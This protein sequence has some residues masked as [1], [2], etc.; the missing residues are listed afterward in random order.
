M[1]ARA[2]ITGLT[3]GLCVGSLNTPPTPTKLADWLDNQGATLG[4]TYA[5]KLHRHYR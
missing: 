3:A 1:L 4:Q 2:E 5:S